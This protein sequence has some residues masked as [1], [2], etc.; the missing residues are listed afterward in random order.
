M[1]KVLLS[2]FAVI[3]AVTFSCIPAQAHKVK[4]FGAT[5]VAFE[6]GRVM[7]DSSDLYFVSLQPR[8]KVGALTLG[9]EFNQYMDEDLSMRDGGNDS[10]ILGMAEYKRGDR[11]KLYYGEIENITFGSGFIVSNYRTNI[12]GNVPLSRQKGLTVDIANK[13]SY[14]KFFGTKTDLYGLRGVH[15]FGRFTLGSTV[16]SDSDPDFEIFGIDGEMSFWKNSDDIKLYG[17]LAGIKDY[18]SGFAVG[19]MASPHKDFDAKIEVRDYDSD[20]APGIV[21][22]HY[23]AANVFN[24][25]NTTSGRMYGIFSCVDLFSQR[26]VSASIS[27]ERYEDMKPRVTL[28]AKAKITSRVRGELFMAEQNFVPKNGLVAEN[29]LA[30]ATAYVKFS[31][32]GELILDYYKAYDDVP[33]KLD[34][35]TFKVKYSLF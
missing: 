29:T 21:D 14:V 26:D 20:F 18:G 32:K 23:E 6:T 8:F 28:K 19:A 33:A 3:T 35:L 34:S 5:A 13:D 25:L 11:L 15:K 7:Q 17:E 31:R 27:Y 22:E 12:K 10:I 9:V 1:K 24:R 30:R 2:L 16:V 4:S